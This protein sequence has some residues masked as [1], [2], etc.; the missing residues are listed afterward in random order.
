MSVYNL[1]FWKDAGERALSTAVQVLGGLVSVD[2]LLNVQS[3]DYKAILAAML[4]AALLSIL[5][6]L[7][8]GLVGVKG[9]ASLSNA[10][11]PAKTHVE[12]LQEMVPDI[13]SIVV[14]V[15]ERLVRESAVIPGVVEQVESRVR[16]IDEVVRE[17]LSR[18]GR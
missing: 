13:E 15:Q 6:S 16:S 7:A 2:M 5:K 9:S 10:V 3:L 11:E 18:L 1:S 4:S 8:A 17:Q 12:R 14:Q